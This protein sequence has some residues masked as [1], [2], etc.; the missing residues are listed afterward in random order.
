[1]FYED[2]GYD[3]KQL[4]DDLGR[5]IELKRQ[6]FA[7]E[8]PDVDPLAVVDFHGRLVLGD[9]LVARATALAALAHLS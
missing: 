5:T 7:A 6:Q 2:L 4:A 3:L 1:M 9:L 8:M